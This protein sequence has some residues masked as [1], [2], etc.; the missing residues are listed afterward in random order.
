MGGG[1]EILEFVGE[2]KGEREGNT[3]I[4]KGQKKGHVG[5]SKYKPK[6]GSW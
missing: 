2:S 4:R 1:R 5:T 3:V 6:E